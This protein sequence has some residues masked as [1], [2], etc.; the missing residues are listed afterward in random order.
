MLDLRVSQRGGVEVATRRVDEDELERRLAQIYDL[1]GTTAERRRRHL[2]AAGRGG[3]TT[4]RRRSRSAPPEP[5][6][7]SQLN[8][9]YTELVF[10]RESR[11]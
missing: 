8:P 3:A 9:C 6:N 11:P 10:G 7:S 5:A 1:P 2:A 4:P